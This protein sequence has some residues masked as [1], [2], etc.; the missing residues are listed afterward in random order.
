MASEE[1][2]NEA[3]SLRACANCDALED[4]PDT[5]LI[6][7][8]RCHMVFYCSRACQAQHFKQKPAGH[9]Q[10]CFT[11]EERRP[12]AAAASEKNISESP[13]QLGAVASNSTLAKD[14][15]CAI[16]LESLDPSS[17]GCCTLPCSHVFHA[18]CAEGL[19]SFDIAQV[20]PICRADLPPG[21]QQL[22]E[23][24]CRLYLP[25]KQLVERSGGLWDRLTATQRRTIDDTLDSWKGAAEQGHADAQWGLGNMYTEG[26]GVP[27]S[28]KEAGVWFRKAAD[29]GH[30]EAQCSLG[31]SYAQGQ[32]MPQS[33]KEAAVWYRKAADQGHAKAQCNLG[34]MYAQGQG[35]PQSYKEAAVWIRKA[36]DQGNANAQI[37]L[38]LSYARG[39][40]VP[41]SSKEAAVWFRKAADQGDS[42]AQCNLG[43]MYGKGHGVPKNTAK[44]LSWFRKAAAQGH[45]GALDCVA[46]LE[47]AEPPARMG[48][49]GCANCG[50]LEANGG[51]ALK[52]CARCKV[53]AYC[54][55]E[56][57]K[58]HWKVPNGHKYFCLP[59]VSD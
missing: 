18:S 27:Q 51:G 8:S 4:P 40:G 58:E 39:Q 43:A 47:A 36:A 1:P 44:A 53:V 12:A 24:G 9:K 16:C 50:A 5:T 23:Q 52:P 41:Q 38:G 32:G 28:F 26:Q 31:L 10:F 2:K 55:R 54:G 21:P 46:Q 11:P 13:S 17:A 3:T 48:P 45:Q 6:A 22:F 33:Y 37:N 19:R 25:S 7:C 59:A 57:Q 42:Q 35:V 20:C 29:Q 49:G 34:A 30:A 14:G 15:E 56:C